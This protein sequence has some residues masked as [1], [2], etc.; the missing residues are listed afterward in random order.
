MR[1]EGGYQLA[2][3]H[4]YWWQGLGLGVGGAPY[5]RRRESNAKARGR[6]KLG[7]ESCVAKAEGKGDCGGTAGR[8][9]EEKEAESCRSR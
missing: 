2:G 4:V 7:E 1:P 5:S 6:K 9:M 3:E 8:E